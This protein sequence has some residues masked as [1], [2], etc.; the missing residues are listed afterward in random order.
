MVDDCGN[1]DREFEPDTD[2]LALYRD[3]RECLVCLTN[4]DAEDTQRMMIGKLE[5]QCDGS[6][7]SMANLN[8]VCWAIGSIAGALSESMEKS[9]LV[10]VINDLLQLCR[11]RRGKDHKAV[12]ASNIMYIVGQY[13]RFLR[14]HWKFLKTVVLKLF[15]FMHELFPGV[16]DM[17]VNTLLRISKKCKRKFVTPQ[18]DATFQG[19]YVEV[20]LSHIGEH[21]K[22]LEIEQTLTFYEAIAEMVGSESNQQKQQ[23]LLY[24]LM[25]VPNQTWTEIIAVGATD[26]KALLDTKVIRQLDLVL[27]TNTRV[28]QTIGSAFGPQLGR[29]FGEALKLYRAYS[30]YIS[31]RI[32]TEGEVHA[33]HADIRQMR[34]VKREVLRLLTSFITRCAQ[35]DHDLLI[36]QILPQ[37][38]APVLDDFRQSVPVVRDSEVLVLFAEAVHRLD[39]LIVPMVPAIFESTFQST[40]ELIT[41]NFHDYP[42]HRVAFFKLL[43]AISQHA[44]SALLRFTPQQFKLILD[45]ILW[46]VKHLERE[47]A[48]TGLET[49]YDTLSHVE[50]SEFANDF[51]RNYYMPLVSDLLGVLTDTLHKTGFKMQANCLA[52][53]LHLVESS[54]ITAPLWVPAHPPNAF[55]SNQVFVRQSITQLLCKQFPN[56]AP[57]QV[58]EFVVQLLMFNDSQHERQFRQCLGDFLIRTKE[59]SADPSIITAQLRQDDAQQRQQQQQQLQQQRATFIPGLI[60]QSQLNE[61]ALGSDANAADDHE[62]RDTL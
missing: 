19:V 14:Q 10:R 16:R 39:S 21:I 28:C 50:R 43:S 48:D 62:L 11:R 45:S 49:L 24:T 46:A 57:Q 58:G 13:P 30:S 61:A 41:K 9:L 22:D 8:T 26:P 56:V 34:I 31:Q 23:Q 51:Y 52:K 7:Y 4:L 29:I 1:V 53:L 60:P 38:V 25:T 47:V 18:D 35:A 40:M 5:K 59:F 17:A 33:K 44:F 37:L 15:E 36:K 6:E 20:I 12:I 42:E 27:K 54:A 3:M 32:T 55:P 2:A